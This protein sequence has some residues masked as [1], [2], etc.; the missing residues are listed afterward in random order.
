MKNLRLHFFISILILLVHDMQGAIKPPVIKI[1]G[2]DPVVVGV[3]STYEITS[4]SIV[5]PEWDITSGSGTIVNTYSSGD[6]YYAVVVWTATSSGTLHFLNEV[7]TY[8]DKTK[9]VTINSNTV[10]APSGTSGTRCGTGT[11]SLSAS[12]SGG[13]DKVRWYAASTGGTYLAENTS[14]TTPSIST[15]TTY[16]IVTW[17]S[18]TSLNSY[19]RTAITAT[20]TTTPSLPSLT[21][22]AA[23]ANVSI[24]LSGTPGANGNVIRWYDQYSGGT[25]LAENNS[26]A[27]PGLSVT[28]DYYASSYNTSTGCEGARDAV[29]ASVQ[30]TPTIPTGG[31]SQSACGETEFTFTLTT[32]TN[33]DKVFWYDA[34]SAGTLL[35]TSPALHTGTISSSTNYYAASY[36]LT[37]GCFS[38]RIT[39]TATVNPVV[40]APSV[41]GG[42]LCRSDSIE[43]TGTAGS[44]GTTLIWYTSPLGGDSLATGLTFTTPILTSTTPYYAASFNATT[45]CFSTTRAA[46]VTEVNIIPNVVTLQ[47]QPVYGSG[48]VDLWAYLPYMNNSNNSFWDEPDELGVD[49]SKFEVKWYASE[50]NALAGTGVLANGSRFT[51]PEISDSTNYYV[52]IKDKESACYADV[53][54]VTARLTPLISNASIQTDIIRVPGK[55]NEAAL[56]TLTDEERTTSV[57]YLD[58]MGRVQQQVVVKGS[59]DGKDLVAPLE[60]DSWG[61]TSKSY[62]PYASTTTNGS[63]H[64][65][66]KVEQKNFYLASG[67]EIADDSVAYALSIYEDSPLGRMIGQS[68]S[69]KEFQLGSGHAQAVQ[70]VF[71]TSGDQVRKFNPDGTSSGYYAANTLNKAIVTDPEGNHI[72]SFT[73]G[74]GQT[75]LQ[76]QQLDETI[77][78]AFVDYLETYTIY[79]VLNQ[80]NYII[81]PKGVSDMKAASWTFSTDI[82]NNYTNQ[83]IYDSKNRLIEKKIPGQGWQYIIYDPLGRVVLTQDGLLRGDNKWMF[84][85][86]DYKGRG[87]MSGLHTNTTYTTRSTMQAYAD[88]LYTSANGTF[89]ENSWYETK[90]STL[91]GYT[92][93]SFPNST[94]EVLAVSYYDNHDFDNSGTDDQEYIIDTLTNEHTPALYNIGRATGSKRKILNTST[95]LYTYV[96]YDYRGR[97]IQVQSNNHLNSDSISDRATNVYANDGR[98]LF[99]KKHHDADSGRVTTVLNSYEYDTKG[100]LTKVNQGNNGATPFT[101]VKYTYNELGQMVDKK[102]HHLGSEQYL[103]SVDYRYNLHGQLKSINDSELSGS[104]GDAETD[105]FGMELFYHDEDTGIANDGLFNGNISAIKWKGAG[106]ASGAA[107]QHSYKYSYDKTS[108]LETATFKASSASDWDKEVNAQNETLTYDQNGNIKTLQRNQRKHELSGLV[109]S[110]AS[111]QIDNLTY[112]YSSTNGNQLL[113][114]EDSSTNPKGFNNGATS[115]TEM[116]YDTQGNLI[117]DTNKGIDAILYTDFGK[118]EEVQY[119]S[120]L[121]QVYT[122]DAAG[123]KLTLKTY[124][125]AT[126]QHTTDYVNGFVYEDGVLS[127]FGAPEGRVVKNGSTLEHQYAIADHQGNT[128][129]VFTSA[130][131]TPQ[132]VTATMEASTNSNFDNYPTGAKRSS[133]NL[134]DHTDTGTTYTYSNYLNGGYSG[135]VGVAKSYQVYPG[136]K[137]KIE[138][139]AKYADP[140]SS[141]SSN[142]TAFAAA[143]LG[144]FGVAAPGGGETGTVASALNQF[145]SVVAGGNGANSSSGPKAFVNI[146]IF[147]K[148]F[149]FLD[150][151]YEAIDPAAEQVGAS[152][153]VPH[154]TLTSEY[155]IKEAGYVFMYVSNEDEDLVDVYFDDVTMTYTPGRVIQSNEYY[156]FGMQAPTSWTRENNTKNNFLY[157]AGTELNSSSGWYE[158]LFRGYDASLGRF[159]QVDPL[160]HID[161]STS[162]FAYAA[163]SPIIFNDPLG[164]LVDV[165]GQSDYQLRA[166]Y[167]AHRGNYGNFGDWARDN[168]DFSGAGGAGRIVDD[169]NGNFF[170]VNADGQ[171]GQFKYF[172]NS[173]H[174]SDGVQAPWAGTYVTREWVPYADQQTNGGGPAQKDPNKSWSENEKARWG[175]LLDGEVM[176]FLD[177]YPDALYFGVGGGGTSTLKGLQVVI[178]GS[179]DVT[180]AVFSIYKAVTAN[181]GVYWGMTKNFAQRVAQHGNRFVSITEEYINISTKAAARGL[182]QLKMDGA[183]GVKKLENA[184][185]SVGTNNPRLMEYYNEAIKYLKGL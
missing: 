144:A 128:R 22:G 38:N 175:L 160:A 123:S 126:L 161:P 168:L 70:Y 120:G 26:Y 74:A 21:G 33:G 140:S 68:Q 105:Y 41:V 185:N 137:V 2:P 176:G 15:T 29:T 79:N 159:L 163:N 157:N 132:V 83:F 53:A 42:S 56:S 30:L 31:T 97:T 142:V 11:V 150:L 96:F 143:L 153:V 72:I 134:F 182:E 178:N 180:P 69:G 58:G 18:S 119:S 117:K 61:R 23:C 162:P 138:A 32:G 6:T 164:L 113:Q 91:E 39:L 125:G 116:D 127:F 177:Y 104:D 8:I 122:Y 45:G 111:E 1:S 92:S 5:Y 50:S 151:A 48:T 77:D 158:T 46:A 181:G 64:S 60:F 155:T 85:K 93:V 17:N 169:G 136:D 4:S 147:D 35:G 78:A 14:Y 109:S 19:P 16:Y 36:N 24:S 115:S 25:L 156:P 118:V 87:V 172:E 148:D 37:T 154:D 89:V 40:G 47:S 149:N 20:V 103:Q 90:G 171:F 28:T 81:S 76:R 184:I 152:P 110:Y 12:P 34:P 174:Y 114:V 106:V 130:A 145:G 65:G 146:L 59:P 52:R 135:Q 139:Y 9:T 44:N 121:K 10:G 167:R 108:K 129:I 71:N 13:G 86:Y 75:V 67:D 179:K 99:A 84:V 54:L 57:V 102:L 100:R 141:G 73:N 112:T 95:W 124:Q 7:G 131:A 82:K 183:G 98:V 63:F 107:G 51:T 165:S 133:V 80:V 55:K 173:F 101:L 27:T 3:E 88:A 94:I 166:L 49:T 43:L 66:Y 62:L 170:G